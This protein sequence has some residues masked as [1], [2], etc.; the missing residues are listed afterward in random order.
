MDEASDPEFCCERMQFDVTYV[1]PKTDSVHGGNP[2]LC[3]DRFF[4]I[5]SDGSYGLIVHDLPD[6]GDG[7]SSV[8][9]A[10][11]PWCG[12]SLPAAQYGWES[13]GRIVDLPRLDPDWTMPDDD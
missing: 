7:L 1:C 10:F 13:G 4:D 3:M 2:L 11:C 6:E 12:R 5:R 8:T 9:V